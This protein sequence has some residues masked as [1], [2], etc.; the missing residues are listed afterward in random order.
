MRKKTRLCVA[1]P[2]SSRW[3]LL[4]PILGPKVFDRPRGLF[5]RLSTRGDGQGFIVKDATR[6]A[7][8]KLIH[9]EANPVRMIHVRSK[10][11][12][13]GILDQMERRLAVVEETH[14]FTGFRCQKALLGGE[15][16]WREGVHQYV[17]DDALTDEHY[18]NHREP[19]AQAA[20][21][22]RT[23][24]ERA[25][26]RQEECVGIHRVGKR[27]LSVCGCSH[28]TNLTSI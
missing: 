18:R 28:S 12:V 10:S 17:A 13:A 24:A 23:G 3:L 21:A 7:P 4:D 16:S 25:G 14:R 2:H 27:G 26:V 8:K 5:R 22:R 20:L 19:A 9:R 6:L 15:A 1:R 11:F